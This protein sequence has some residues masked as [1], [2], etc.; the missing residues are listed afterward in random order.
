[1]SRSAWLLASST[2]VW[3][4]KWKLPMQLSRIKWSVLLSRVYVR[5]LPCYQYRT[6]S[7][8]ARAIFKISNTK[9]LAHALQRVARRADV[10]VRAGTV[11]KFQNFK[12][13]KFQILKIFTQNIYQFLRV[14]TSTE[15]H[16]HKMVHRRTD[17][18]TDRQTHTQTLRI[19]TPHLQTPAARART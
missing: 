2:S 9:N 13:S 5:M 14:Q 8:A 10:V 4:N 3:V 19:R 12:I 16:I 11:S 6:M 7:Y 17:R 1:M 18:Q 15:V